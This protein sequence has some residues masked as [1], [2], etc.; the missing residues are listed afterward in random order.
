MRWANVLGVAQTASHLL[1]YVL[2]VLSLHTGA[3]TCGQMQGFKYLALILLAL[4]WRHIPIQRKAKTSAIV[5]ILHDEEIRYLKASKLT[6]PAELGP[7]Q[8]HVATVTYRHTD[9]S[10]ERRL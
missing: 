6:R 10:K 2:P 3:Q 8:T 5:A 7:L 1:P 4:I 9:A